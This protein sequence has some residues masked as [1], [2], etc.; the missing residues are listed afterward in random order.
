MTTCA[1]ISRRWTH[2]AA[3]ILGSFALPAANAAD[4]EVHRFRVLLDGKPIGTHQ[5]E[6]TRAHDGVERVASLARFDVKILGLTVYRY[7]HEAQEQWQGGCLTGMQASTSDNGRALQVRA[8]LKDGALHVEAPRADRRDDCVVAYAYWD[9][10]RLLAQRELLNPQTGEF[11]AVRIE[12]LGEE[13]LD[14]DGRPR[15]AERYRL[16]GDELAIDLWYSPQ[17]EW[18]QLAS[19]ARGDRQLLYQTMP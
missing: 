15:P 16:S 14:V 13:S 19:A 1:A 4:G 18:L 6:I 10:D 17:G 9:R 7:R 11:D 12:S 2:T 3:V 5:F 8:A